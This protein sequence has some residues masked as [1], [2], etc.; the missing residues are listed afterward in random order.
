MRW[1]RALVVI[2]Q[3]R[4]FNRFVHIELGGL[5]VLYMVLYMQNLE[6]WALTWPGKS[7]KPQQSATAFAKNLSDRKTLDQ[8]P[9]DCR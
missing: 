7:K 6:I 3:N 9:I 4:R 8:P 5:A 1:Y 2:D